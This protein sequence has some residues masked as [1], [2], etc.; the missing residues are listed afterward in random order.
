MVRLPSTAED[1]RSQSFSN[2]SNHLFL[3]NISL[4]R[5]KTAYPETDVSG[6]AHYSSKNMLG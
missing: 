1:T 5:F 6:Y 2:D 4:P 3:Q